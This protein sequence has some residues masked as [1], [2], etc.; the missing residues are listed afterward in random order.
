MARREVVV[1]AHIIRRCGFAIV[2]SFALGGAAEAQIVVSKARIGCLDIQTEG[3][4]TAIV[5]KACNGKQTC[6]YK[7][8]K[9]ADYKSMGVKASTRSFCTQGMEITYHCGRNDFHT[10]TIAGDAWNNPPAQLVCTPPSPTHRPK[11]GLI[12][13]TGAR[14]GCLDIQA[15][16]NLTSLAA[17][18][19]NDKKTCSY[20]APSEDEY[21]RAGVQARTRTFCTQAMEITYN[22]GN[23]DFHSVGVEGDAWT[24]PPAVLDCNAPA[25]ASMPAGRPDVVQVT[26]AR[27]GCLDIQTE[28]NLT[29][30]VAAACNHRRSCTYKAPTESEYKRAGVQA[31][32]RSLCTQAMEI[33]YNCGRNDP[34]TVMVEGDAWKNP[35]AHLVCN[36]PPLPAGHTFPAGAGPITVT[37]ARIGCLDIQ[38]DANLTNLVARSCNG[39]TSCWYKA[40]TEAAYKAAG[41]RANTRPMCTQGMEI[42]YRCGQNDE[43]QVKVDGDAWLHPPAELVCDGKTIATNNQGFTPPPQG[44]PTEPACHPPTVWTPDPKTAT[45]Y[46]LAPSNMLDWTPTVSTGDYT[47]IGFRP[48]DSATRNIYRSKPGDVRG[49]PGST[50]GA[51]EGR[52]RGELRA[53]AK[54]KDPLAA[55]C[56]AAQ[57]FTTNRPAPDRDTPSDRDYGNAFADLAVTGRTA[58]AAFVKQRPTDATLRAH[59]ACAGAAVAAVDQALD[60]AYQGAA[61]LRLPH[62]SRERQ[63]L[64]WMAVS[65]EDDQ[66]YRPVNVP[67]T[68]FPQFD[69]RVDTPGWSLP[70]DTRYMIAHRKAPNFTRAPAPLVDGGGPKRQVPAD[71]LPALADD[72]Q[73]LLFIHGMDSRTEEAEDLAASLH[74]LGDGK[75][76][77]V[78]SLDLP[79][80]GYATNLDPGRISAA[81][82]VSCH[83][84]RLLDFMEDY[85]VAFVDTLDRKLGGKLK[86]KIRAAVGGSLGGN[87]TMR[88]SRRDDLALRAGRKA[89]TPWLT[90]VVSWSPAAIWPSFIGRPN[91]AAC[92]C[93]T[94][95]DM[96]KDR[97][98]NLALRWAGRSN[99]GERFLPSNETPE[100][101]R[102]LFYG[103]FDWDGG[104]LL[105]IT[106]NVRKPQAQCWYSDRWR[107]KDATVAASR[108]DRQETYDANFRAWRWRLGAEQLAFSQ[109]QNTRPGLNE[110]DDPLYLYNK[111]PMLLFCGSEDVCGDLC[112]HTRNVAA[113][114]VNTPGYARFLNLTGHSIPNEH[115]EYMAREIATF[116]ASFPAGVSRERI[117]VAK[118]RI[119]C[120]DIQTDGNMTAA[121]GR[122]CNGK[123]TCSYQAPSEAAYKAMGVEARTRALCTQGMEINYQCGRN[124]FRTAT[125]RGDAW[126]QPP[127]TLSCAPPR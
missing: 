121:V 7:A 125:I 82:E 2:A 41:V 76:W 55:L 75:N 114:M 74:H 79:S 61:A 32:T 6:S 92:G 57:R 73:V 102:E 110:Y 69:I 95:W 19:C 60:R 43:R 13:V 51:N 93:D 71:P 22:C 126:K 63:A 56:Q 15:E 122:S 80:S 120:L 106:G 27:I 46:I 28:G 94:G 81:S 31:R 113:R 24:K 36:P 83:K 16:M 29:K 20:K 11:P 65:G 116:L 101:R 50:L 37:K 53:V 3:N 105:E 127:A 9:E 5:G 30:V 104:L 109:R 90:H 21:K 47:M 1:R 49:S 35:P 103:G 86:P 42:A 111:K 67:G 44:S 34:Q 91:C 45:A 124:D 40:P 88:L 66:P 8:P 78:I 89:D 115:P 99:G 38:H 52:V 98:V 70:V 77:T 14:I 68:A 87:M 84:T 23:E 58:F 25:S 62:S 64:G 4:M 39:R 59:P 117:E 108:I 119:G 10:A 33:T 17:A 54:K 18:A 118:A 123:E 100:L 26:K 48:P 12:T 107:C 85:I 72:A 112:K 97:A 96:G